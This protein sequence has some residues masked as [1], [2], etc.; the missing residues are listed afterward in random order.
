M[1]GP[2]DSAGAAPIES[3]EMLSL[4][5]TPIGIAVL[6]DAAEINVVVNWFEQLERL[7][8]TDK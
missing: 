3:V 8:P 2:L 5:Q 4:F 7:V 1:A 6:P